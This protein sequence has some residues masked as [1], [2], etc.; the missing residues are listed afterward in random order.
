MITVK[1]FRGCNW[2]KLETPEFKTYK[3]FFDFYVENSDMGCI[4]DVLD[5]GETY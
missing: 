5:D 3:E 2:D 4:F 1:F